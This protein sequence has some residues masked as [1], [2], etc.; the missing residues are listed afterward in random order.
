MVLINGLAV[1]VV[2][3]ISIL[4][5]MLWYGPL[6]GKLWMR[7]VGM[8]KMSKPK[9][10]GLI[11]LG[12]IVNVLILVCALAYV[13]SVLGI[14]SAGFGIMWGL[15]IWFG[16]MIPLLFEPVLWTKQKLSV[17]FINAGY[18]LVMMV[19]AGAILGMW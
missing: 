12:M 2:A 9:N 7:G 10:M 16:F 18:R 1:L 15:I 4:L 5:G 11:Y 19:I 13:L 3:V 8:K 17:F 14:V 6:F